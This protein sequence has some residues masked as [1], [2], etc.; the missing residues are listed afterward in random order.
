M[1][2]LSPRTPLTCG[3]ASD[4]YDD[5]I[6]SL[7]QQLGTLFAGLTRWG[8]LER[9]VVIVTADHGEQFGEHGH[10]RHGN[11][12]YEPEIHVP[13]VIVAPSGVP[14][15]R[16]VPGPVSLRDIPA[17]VVDLL[18]WRGESPFP[19][20]SLARTWESPGPPG[21]VKVDLTL[22]ELGPLIEPTRELHSTRSDQPISRSQH[23]ARRFCVHRSQGRR[24]GTLQPGYRSRRVARPQQVGQ[25][26]A[27]AR[28]FPP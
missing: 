2:G 7:D 18:G 22:A 10:F 27:H 28:A 14:A 5:C 24:R 3:L 23:F 8:L 6:A 19:G 17:T 25:A 1:K 4:A 21:R 9:T 20:S 15:G 26:G 11:S 12:L 13:L 16:V